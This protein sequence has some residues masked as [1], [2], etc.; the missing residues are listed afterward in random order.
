MPFKDFNFGEYDGRQE[1]LRNP[2]YFE[3]SYVLPP[4][5]VSS[6]I[7]NRKNFILVGPKGVGK[8]SLQLHLE[9]DRQKDG[10]HTNFISFY[11]DLTSQ[12]YT[13][14]SK[15]QK[16]SFVEVIEAKNIA[17]LYDF[18]DIWVR[19][20][21]NKMAD[22]LESGGLASK[23]TQLMVRSRSGS[24]SLVDGIVS[25]LKI[26]ADFSAIFGALNIK[27]EKDFDPKSK[28]MSLS[29][30]N[31]IA[32]D[33]LVEF[34]KDSKLFISIDELIV[35]NW[36]TKSDEY[37]ARLALI[38]DIL[39]SA[40]YINN[41]FVRNEL[42]MHIVCS[43]R[44]EV[45]NQLYTIDADIS[46]FMDSSS[47][48]LSWAATEDLNHPLIG[49]I[50]QKIMQGAPEGTDDLSNLGLDN[51]VSFTSPPLV[52]PLFIL[53]ESWHR[54]RDVVRFLKCYAGSNPFEGTFT[55]SGVS[56]SLD[57]YSRISARE[58]FDEIAVKYSPE[59]IESLRRAL[60]K[61]NYRDSID[62]EESVSKRV[63]GVS[64]YQEF[65]Q[66]LFRVGVITNIDHTGKQPRYFAAHRGNEFVDPE[67][68]ISV[69]PGLWNYLSIRHKQ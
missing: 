62:F 44:P 14:F 33:Q 46:K 43:I 42:D 30:F 53:K 4:S 2:S 35:S 66:D 55:S 31:K 29:E 41:F 48:Q 65:L 39:K 3:R 67:I 45:R 34:N 68:T 23:F 63:I 24:K 28:E 56:K 19:I 26:K 5:F 21:L 51:K 12:E 22:T 60:R 25:G 36:H 58:C 13:E 6:S 64:D 1:Y 38:R 40:N 18:R 50:S 57:E 61:T 52:I 59:T 8:S 47:A 69:H 27:V 10:Y 15:T 32:M 37:K 16:I 49:L 17:A 9:N 11:D 20:I 54:P 7:S